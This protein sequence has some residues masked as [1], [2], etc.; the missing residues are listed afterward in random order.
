MNGGVHRSLRLGF[1]ALYALATLLI[2]VIVASPGHAES[3]AG[4]G[5]GDS[6]ATLCASHE[7]PDGERNGASTC[8]D[9]CQITHGVDLPAPS[10]AITVIQREIATRLCFLQ[11]FGRVADASPDDLRSRAPPTPLI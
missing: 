4:I 7:S 6:A 5:A 9:A 3:S 10:P 11:Q 1:A 2:A 8:C